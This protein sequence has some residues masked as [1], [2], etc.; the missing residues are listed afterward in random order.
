[1]LTHPFPRNVLA[2][3]TAAGLIAG[4][5]FPAQ[6]QPVIPASSQGGSSQGIDALLA[7]EI[8][9]FGVR[10]P[11]V[12]AVGGAVIAIAG[13]VG[14]SVAIAKLVESNSDDVG[15]KAGIAEG[16]PHP[17]EEVIANPSRYA[18]PGG[19]YYFEPNG[20]YQYAIVE[21]TGDSSPELLLQQMGTEINPVTVFTVRNGRAVAME[22]TLEAGAAS[23]GGYRAG[24]AGAT[25]GVGLYAYRG[26]S[27]NP[28]HELQRY[29]IRGTKL[30]AGEK[31]SYAATKELPA[32]AML[33]QWCSTL[34]QTCL[35]NGLQS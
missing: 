12:Q 20:K 27:L 1:M 28:N 24:V 2:V 19:S 18:R 9:V 23:A 11:A 35:T 22:N 31:S 7:N 6:A 5:T 8:D 32:S 25:N 21:A 15:G 17:Y 16:Q 13:L 10:I 29:T 4:T 30:Q 3:A 33:L 26:L 14:L 34:N